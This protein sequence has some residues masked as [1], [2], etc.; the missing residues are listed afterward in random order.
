MRFRAPLALGLTLLL[1]APALAQTSTT[2]AFLDPEDA[3][4]AAPDITRVGATRAK[5]GDVRVAIS[6]AGELTAQDLLATS[7]PPGSVCVR[8]W[9]QS[10]PG[11][12][13][14]DLLACVTSRADGKTLRSTITKEVPGML[15]ST[16]GTATLTRPSDTS[17]ALIVPASLIGT[18]TKT[19]RFAA[20]ATRPGCVRI[21]CT[22]LAPALGKPR[23]LKLR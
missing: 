1:A 12:T 9:T 23:A 4:E 22:D 8:M 19:L 15:P 14:P 10:T 16:V 6:F 17:L 21:S 3:V 18:T 5:S 20:E 11:T 2:V 13:A 7:G